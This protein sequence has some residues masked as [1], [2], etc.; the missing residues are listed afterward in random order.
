MKEEYYS[1]R[2]CYQFSTE[3]SAL[4]AY[5]IANKICEDYFFMEGIVELDVMVVKVPSWF[6][7]SPIHGK[8]I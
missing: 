1:N 7:Y 5:E 6:P 8:R 4:Q 2:I 3:E